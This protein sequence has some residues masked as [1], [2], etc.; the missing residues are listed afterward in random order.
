MHY[1]I[2]PIKSLANGKRRL[3]SFLPPS[4]RRKLILAL[5]KDVL[6]STTTS[7][8]SDKTLLVTPDSEIIKITQNW[9]FPKLEYLFE[10]IAQGTNQ[11]V[12]FALDWCQNKPISSILIIPAD[13]PLITSNDIDELLQLGKS[14]F[15]IILI[16]SQRKD[17]TNAFYQSPPNL[18]QVWYG[19]NSFQKNLTLISQRQIPYKILENPAFA[20]DIDIK[21]DLE[22]LQQLEEKSATSQFMKTLNF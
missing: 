21:E 12:Q 4:E 18:V 20:L 11:A 13:I 7:K 15:S 6:A 1:T 19:A 14:E 22:K 17:G 3:E 8:L 9:N 10:P 5:L 16:P 2:I